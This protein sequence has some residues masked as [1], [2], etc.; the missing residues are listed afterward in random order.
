METTRRVLTNVT[1]PEGTHAPMGQIIKM[2][3]Y[4]NASFRDVTAPNADTPLNIG[5][6]ALFTCDMW[7]H[8]YYIDY[9]NA[10]AKYLE[11][12]WKLLNW[13]F[14]GKNFEEKAIPELLNTR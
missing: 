11:A 5:H 10:R 8:A 12:F 9:R 14:A 1:A 3:E 13:N 4:P 7:E 2:R 6:Q